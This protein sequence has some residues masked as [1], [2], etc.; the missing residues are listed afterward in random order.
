MSEVDDLAPES[1]ADDKSQ[2][3][4]IH[5]DRR[6]AGADERQRDTGDR[7]DADGHSDIF[8]DL[9]EKHGPQTDDD[10]ITVS[11]LRALGDTYDAVH[12]KGIEPDDCSAAQKSQLFADDGEDEVG[13][14]HRQKIQSF[15]FSVKETLSEKTSGSDGDL[16]IPN[17]IIRLDAQV[18]RMEKGV[19]QSGVGGGGSLRL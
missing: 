15:L 12:E 1:Y 11:I 14:C 16:G 5:D 13:F 2:G 18:V 4:H 9:E 3:D 6:A 17:L 10:Q 8:K 7:H 19:C